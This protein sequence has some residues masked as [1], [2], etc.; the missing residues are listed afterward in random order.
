MSQQTKRI[1]AGTT[2]LGSI[3]LALTLFPS[4]LHGFDA[5]PPKSPGKLIVHEW[6]TFTNF[7]GSNGVNLEFRPLATRDLP[8]FVMTPFNQPG[9]LNRAL[10]KDQFYARQRME[11][12]VTYFYTDVPRTVNARVDFPQGALTEWYPVVKKFQS[13]KA[14]GSLDIVGN[15]YLDWGTVRLTPPK[16]FADIRVKGPKGKA[17]P[18]SLPP[19][20][21]NDHYGRARETD[22]AIVET[23]DTDH[24]SHFEKFLFYRG[25]GNF[26]LPMKL[27]ALGDDRFEITNSGDEAS[28]ASLLMRIDRG[29]VRF[30]RI[31]P[32]SPRSMI[33]VKL[34][35][36]ESTVD[37]LSEATVRELTAVGLYEKESLAMVNT[38]RTNWFGENGTRLLYLVP[39]K[40][41]D[42]LL[43]LKVDPAPDEQVRVLVGRLETITPEDCQQLV[44]KLV[45][46]GANDQPAE[47]WVKEELK[48]LGRFAEPAIQFAISQTS[49]PTQLGRLKVIL[50]TV[51]NGR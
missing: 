44:R 39:Q 26:E 51:R 50:A 4:L 31:D 32:V 9:S 20:D 10:L 21:A 45:G 13:G 36:T 19:V 16:Q 46:I 37:Q 29:L 11:T 30:T 47:I 40:Q 1:W 49:D 43:P 24:A 18:A 25:L 2:I 41:T 17:F 27:T 15:A 38:W 14:D 7:S 3:A 35:E 12:P 34:P 23:I 48:S 42:K 22:S 5:G 28:G 8:R 6:G 33:E